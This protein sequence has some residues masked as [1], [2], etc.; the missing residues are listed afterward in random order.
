MESLSEQIDA[1]AVYLKEER[2]LSSRT[3]E[4]YNRDLKF[5]RRFVHDRNLPADARALDVTALRGF[6]ASRYPGRAP[7]TLARTMAA[8]RSFY[9]FLRIRGVTKN[10]PAAQLLSP[11]VRKPLPEFLTVKEAFRVV[12][13]PPADQTRDS[14]LTCRDGA[15]L[16]LLYGSGVRLGELV[17]L[18][19]AR[20]DMQRGRVRVIGKGNK[21][22][23]V[24]M[25][26]GAK[27]AVA[28]WLRVRPSM[29]HRRTQRLH[30]TALFVAR[31]G[32]A[33]S[34]RQVQNLVRRYGRAGG[35]RVDLHPHTLRHSC[36]THLLDAGAD[37]RTIQE[38]LGHS[39]LSTTQRYTHVT[40]D[41]LM[42][43]YAKAHPL[44]DSRADPSLPLDSPE[45]DS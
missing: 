15:I 18:T 35:A 30:E 28:A 41:R 21:E 37:L 14:R 27:D 12:D 31:G 16:E 1:F 2:R 36:A 40:A 24:P 38:L 13:A 17:S 44:A 22:R 33:L 19:L 6:M 4:T 42:A 23:E 26:S 9:R 39:S 34:G 20:T 29:A 5:L 11:K 43:V 3:V 25:G 8:V 7:A 10:N 45:G 32:R